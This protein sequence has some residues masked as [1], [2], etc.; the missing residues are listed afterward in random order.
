MDWFEGFHC[1]A[2]HREPQDFLMLSATVKYWLTAEYIE[3]MCILGFYLTCTSSLTVSTA[4]AINCS[5]VLTPASRL[6]Y[7]GFTYL[8]MSFRSTE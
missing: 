3:V 5:I 7:T 1:P 4:D 6:R 2:R 8:A